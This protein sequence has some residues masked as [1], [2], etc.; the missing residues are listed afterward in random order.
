MNS[1]GPAGLTRPKSDDGEIFGVNQREHPPPGT[2]V[3]L[4]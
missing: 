1:Y 3:K 4:R 2:S